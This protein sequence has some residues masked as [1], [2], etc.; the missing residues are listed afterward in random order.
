MVTRANTLNVPCHIH[1]IIDAAE[2]LKPDISSDRPRVVVGRAKGADRTCDPVYLNSRKYRAQD[3]DS[4]ANLTTNID[5]DDKG[6]AVDRPP[7]LI[8]AEGKFL[9]IVLAIAR[10]VGSLIAWW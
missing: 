2:L 1:I 7:R 6:R 3:A 8:T 5:M 10:G 9:R 4:H